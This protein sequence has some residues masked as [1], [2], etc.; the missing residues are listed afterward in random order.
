MQDCCVLDAASSHNA[1]VATFDQRLTS[2][3]A[4][5]SV[6]TLDNATRH[7]DTP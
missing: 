3:A 7:F 4:A 6:R 1:A 2:A 5:L